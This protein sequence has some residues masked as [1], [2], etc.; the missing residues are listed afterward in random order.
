MDESKLK[1]QKILITGG[2]M[3]PAL[4][5]MQELRSR[6]FKDFV[7]VG[8]KF[9]QTNATVPS[10]EYQTL[11]AV[12]DV[13]FIDLAAGKLV[14]SWRINAKQ[15]V[16]AL[17]NLAKIP[18]GMIQ[19]LQ[20]LLQEKPAI[21]ISFGGYIAL[22]MVFWAKLL[23]IKAVTHEQTI[24]TGLSNRILSTLADKIFISWP[25]SAAFYPAAKTLLTGNP[26]R[27]EIFQVQ[28][29]EINFNNNLPT[30]YITGGNQGAVILNRAVFGALP[31]IL[32]WA[33]VIHQTGSAAESQSMLAALSFPAELGARY[34]HAEYVFPNMIGEVFAKSTLMVARAG[35]NT[36]CE[37]IA[38]T[39]PTIFVPIPW[40]TQNEQH[41]NA[42][43]A[44]GLGLA[45]ILAQKDLT[46]ESLIAA[47]QNSI[48]QLSAGKGLNGQPWQEVIQKSQLALPAEPTKKIVDSVQALL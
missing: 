13:K 46:S 41:L 47:L 37:A 33:N 28:S 20:I 26:L 32:Q 18:W 39:K 3:T 45:I 10:P 19:G 23:G 7:W 16:L 17:K 40:V 11:T 42:E 14:R 38:L 44:M 1:S 25:S 22:P 12:G 27:P 9:N 2:H 43:Y 8:H 4:A 35:A 34:F 48:G 36:V 6:G 15:L 31:E 5:V 29:N 21:V 30:I 24:I